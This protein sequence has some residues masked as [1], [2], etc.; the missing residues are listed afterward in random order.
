M[1]IEIAKDVQGEI[2]S[3]DSRAIYKYMDI[4]TAKPSI[5]EQQGIAHFGIDL[6]EPGERF[7]VADWKDYA[8]QKIKEIRQRGHVPIIVGGTGLYIDALVYNYQF[9]GKTGEKAGE[10]AS[11]EQKSCSDRQKMVDGF[12]VFGIKW[13]NEALRERLEQRVNK[14][15]V[16][17]L[18]DE[19]RFL[20]EKYGWGSQAMKSDIYQF[21]WGYL[22]GEYSLEEAKRL[23]VLDDYHLA[24]RQMTWFK[25]NPEIKWLSLEKIKPAVLKCIQNG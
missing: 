2:I 25:R 4:G 19:T 8:E 13:D 16:Q 1:G 9:R 6:V 3:A 22:D 11:V 7:T 23:C 21:A 24:K 17:E 5:S 18:Y 10:N 15:F 20:V 12:A 14:L